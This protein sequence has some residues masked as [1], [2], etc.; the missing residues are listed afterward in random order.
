MDRL[1]IDGISWAPARRIF[2]RRVMISASITFAALVAVAL[3]FSLYFGLPT[4]WAFLVA[5]T[6]TCIFVLEDA[7][8]WRSTRMD[9]WQIEA[10]QLIHDGADGRAQVPL[11]EVAQVHTQFGSRVVITLRSGQRMVLRY[12]PF[13]GVVADQIRAARGPVA[14]AG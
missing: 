10:G 9:R 13:P 4:G 1:S 6:L 11:S 3:G 8:H 7:M 2:V 5:L 12:L 14:D